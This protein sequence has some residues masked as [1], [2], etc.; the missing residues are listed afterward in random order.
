MGLPIKTNTTC[1]IYRSSHA[2]PAAPDVAGVAINLESTF[3]PPHLSATVNASTASRWTHIALCDTSID[4]RDAYN[5]GGG[6]VVGQDGYAATF[7]SVYVPDKNGTK[8]A[9][10]FVERV[11]YNSGQDFF[12]VYLQ[13]AAPTWPTANL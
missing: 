10:V 9:V 12:R 5:G 8:F 4:I 2:P 3:G 1:D 11:G 6:T 7:D 13:R